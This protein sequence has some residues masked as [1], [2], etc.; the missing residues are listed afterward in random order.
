MMPLLTFA[1]IRTIQRQH[2]SKLELQTSI[3]TSMAKADTQIIMNQDQSDEK[4]AWEKLGSLSGSLH[5]KFAADTEA[6]EA[7]AVTSIK[8]D[9]RS[10]SLRRKRKVVIEKRWYWIG[11][12][13]TKRTQYE[14]T[15]DVK[16]IWP[17]DVEI[18]TK[19][20]PETWTYLPASW[21]KK[22]IVC[23]H[24]QKSFTP[25]SM[26][27]HGSHLFKAC[28]RGDL[29]HMIELFSSGQGSIYDTLPDGITLL[30]VGALSSHP[31]PFK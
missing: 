29:N 22:A 30:H 18:E 9:K 10:T 25:I 16:G 19:W 27:P 17:D 20:L 28:S 2:T 6:S 7:L 4:A 5:V 21:K 1:Y 3:L 26:V 13:L 24:W 31:Y 15:E 8:D 11:W 23:G 14:T 12:L